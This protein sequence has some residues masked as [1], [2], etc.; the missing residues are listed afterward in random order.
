MDDRLINYQNKPLNTE[1]EDEW[2]VV[3]GCYGVVALPRNE[4]PQFFEGYLKGSCVFGLIGLA[5]GLSAA[6][7]GLLLS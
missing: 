4:L 3:G 6:F 5:L 7:I 2:A 1:T